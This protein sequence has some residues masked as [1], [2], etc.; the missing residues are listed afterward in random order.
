[1]IGLHAISSLEQSHFSMLCWKP[2]RIAVFCC[3]WGI[4][5]GIGVSENLMALG[6]KSPEVQE[7]VQKARKYLQSGN[8]TSRV[9]G[10]AVIA[11][12]L[13]KSGTPKDHAKVKS[14]IDACRK[15]ANGKLAYQGDVVYDAGLALIFL[16]EIDP[17]QYH[18]EIEKLIKFMVKIQK[19]HGGYGY[20]DRPT[21]DNSMTQ[22]PALGLW[23]AREN[24]FEVPIETIAGITNWVMAV[25]DPS[26]A[27]GYQ[28]V[29][30][31]RGK[32][33]M[34]Q[35]EIRPSLTAAGLCSVYVTADALD[36]SSRRQRQAEDIPE[37]F[38]EVSMQQE[39]DV[40]RKARTLVDVEALK[41]VK[42][43]GNKWI[44]KNTTFDKQWNFYFLYALERYKA[45]KELDDGK[46]DPDPKWYSAGYKFIKQ[47]QK[48]DGSM[49]SSNEDS[50][51][52]TGFA[53]LF[54]VRGTAESIK[55]NVRSFDNGLLAGGR[56]LPD[57]LAAAELRNGKV[58][59][60]KQTPDS[61]RLMEML[62]RDDG[63]LDDL[64]DTGV[65][66]DLSLTGEQRD[67]ALQAV[68]R[69]LRQGSYAA[70][71]MSLHAIRD[72]KDFDSVPWLIFALTDPD[73]R[74]VVE[75]RDTL[76]FVSR[77]IDGFGMP[78]NATEGQRDAAVDAWKNWYR[79]LRPDARFLD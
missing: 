5:L 7:I 33:R 56:G 22:Y 2:S 74:I 29:V 1:M 21:G 41:S 11:L 54:L 34:S 50:D 57:D 51:V 20:S 46:P 44:D 64:V 47:K 79:S 65:T 15:F 40:L 49:E 6:P 62:Q 78:R 10:K 9:G 38:M 23:L 14:A 53:V 66:F 72:A 55:H 18:A 35:E 8:E 31:P 61:Q 19:P 36:L 4:F 75:A 67:V 58:V 52:A 37:G 77:K 12:A 70:R 45:F 68:R 30:S 17:E 73:P 69:K 16:C 3:A 42:D 27:F 13:V 76:R 24:R 26:G 63:A 48:G 28:G 43:L 71:L 39:L 32:P 60:A 59:D 25:Q